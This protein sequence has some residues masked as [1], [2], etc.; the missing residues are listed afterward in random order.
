M[1]TMANFNR[2]K[3]GEVF[4]RGFASDDEFGINISRSGKCLRWL[5][6]KGYANDWCIYVA[7]HFES[8]SDEDDYVARVGDKVS[9]KENIRRALPCED[10]VLERYRY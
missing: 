8:V 4:A 6:V 5:A 10:A 3:E 9:M 7:E 1:L 2:V